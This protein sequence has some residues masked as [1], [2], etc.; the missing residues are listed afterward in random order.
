MGAALFPYERTVP[1][2]LPPKDARFCDRTGKTH[3]AAAVALAASK[4]LPEKDRPLTNQDLMERILCVTQSHAAA[5]NLHNR[6]EE[7]VVIGN[8]ITG[9]AQS[10]G[11]AVARVGTTLTPTEVVQQSIFQKVKDYWGEDDDEVSFMEIA[12]EAGDFTGV[13]RSK[14]LQKNQFAVMRRMVL[15]SNVAVMTLASSGNAGLCRALDDDPSA[16]EGPGDLP[17]SVYG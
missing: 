6:L 15:M 11:V 1:G 17:A 13:E 10:F 9:L 2:I 4:N 12:S 7:T 3:V 16:G 14:D 8:K 5:M